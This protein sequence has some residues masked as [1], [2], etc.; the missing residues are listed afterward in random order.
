MSEAPTPGELVEALAEHPHRAALIQVVRHAALD[1]AA[2]RRTDFA[3]RLHDGTTRS[4]TTSL[5]GLG[6]SDADTPF[7]N[8]VQILEHGVSTPTEAL[9]L[10]TLLALSAREEPES[11]EQEVAFVAHVTWLA[12]HTPCDAL[13]ALDAAAGEREALWRALARVALEPAQVMADFGRTEALVAAAALGASESESAAPVRSRAVN[14]AHDAPV[15]ALLA[16]GRAGGEPLEGELQ[17]APLGAVATTLLALTLVLFV[18]QLARLIGRLAFAYR[19]PAALTLTQRGLEL[20]H[21][22]EFLGKVLRDRS[23]IVP[24]A[25]LARV[26]RE[27]KY[28]RVGLYVGLT[29]LV[30]GTYF[31]MGLF[32][33]GLR[34]P[35]GSAPLLAMAIALMVS[36]I[37]LD[38]VLSSALDSTRGRC[39]IVV[40]P[41]KGRPIC[42]G[43]ID[44]LKADQMLASVTAVASGA[45]L[46]PQP[47]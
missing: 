43:A 26:T 23:T 11:E 1:A 24:L 10:G 4:L 14:R 41:R 25:N 9:L 8:V 42:V 44:S 6:P 17:P 2:A 12:T 20:T 35:G 34:V 7:G 39:R 32:V 31:G 33:D 3:S 21:H 30:L 15:R 29:A 37:A 40:F 18:W 38:F 46:F 16:A 36:G 22:V 27:V 45:S 13:L 28:A 47:E 5:E 19:R